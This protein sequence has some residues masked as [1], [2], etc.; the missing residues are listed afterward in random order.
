MKVLR[1]GSLFYYGTN[2]ILDLRHFL[3]SSQKLTDNLARCEMSK[4]IGKDFVIEPNG[5]SRKKDIIY[6]FITE[7]R[8]EV[9][10]NGLSFVRASN[11]KSL[12]KVVYSAGKIG[13]FSCLPVESLKLKF[14]SIEESP[15]DSICDFKTNKRKFEE[16]N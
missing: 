7:D 10:Q 8:L 14:V 9:E 1:S 16:S 4:V 6:V 11:L 15:V 12:R 3:F 2:K 13:C 5:L